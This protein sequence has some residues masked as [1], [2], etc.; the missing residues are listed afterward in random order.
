M[1]TF[2]EWGAYR[3]E[4][5]APTRLKY[6]EGK[7]TSWGFRC[8]NDSLGVVK[9]W[10]KTDFGDQTQ[11]A[12]AQAEVRS[13]YKDYL[14]FLYEQLRLEFTAIVLNGREWDTAAIHFFFSIPATWSPDIVDDF[15]AIARVAGFGSQPGFDVKA[16]LTEP[17]AVAAYTLSSEGFVEVIIALTS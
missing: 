14:T 6:H 16:S 11:T 15:C 7:P 5:K 10:F 12:A 9:E 2:K 13:L 4:D 1:H 3:V 17:H 8:D